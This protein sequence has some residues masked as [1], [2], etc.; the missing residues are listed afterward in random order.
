[1][2][3]DDWIRSLFPV[4]RDT[5]WDAIF[6]ES[7]SPFPSD[8]LG[9]LAFFL[10]ESVS[11]SGIFNY[12]E[13]LLPILLSSGTPVVALAQFLDF[14]KSYQKKFNKSFNWSHPNTK[15]LVYVFG[16]SNFMATRLKRNPEL[17]LKLLES[18]FLFQKKNL[19]E[20]EKG[21]SASPE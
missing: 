15:A 21:S 16:R 8:S 2:N 14:S 10:E 5:D 1:M 13:E 11:I 20:M 3:L 9:K 17:A 7:T 12:L 19:L 18:S 4:S 6:T